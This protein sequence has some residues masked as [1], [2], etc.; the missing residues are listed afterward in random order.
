M[1]Y[2]VLKFWKLGFCHIKGQDDRN[3]ECSEL[4]H[5]AES[6]FCGFSNEANHRDQ[7]RLEHVL[8]TYTFYFESSALLVADYFS[9]LA[10]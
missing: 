4:V 2:S 6:Y 5:D 1:I 10:P 7:W 3:S 9:N 8:M